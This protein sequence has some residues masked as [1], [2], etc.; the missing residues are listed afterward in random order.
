[1]KKKLIVVGIIVAIVAVIAIV[2]AAKCDH[3]WVDATCETPQT[4]SLCGE[5]NGEALG[6]KWVDAT[7]K[8]AKYC[9]VC[10]KIEGEALGHTTE[11]GACERCGEN[12]GVWRFTSY[13]DD[14]NNPTGEGVV[15][16]NL[17]FEGTFSNSAA[18]DKKLYAQL[19][20]DSNDV[21]IMLLEYGTYPV[22]GS[23]YKKYNVTIL[24]ENGKKYTTYAS[25][26]K[27]SDRLYIKDY[28]DII[29]YIQ[30]NEKI[31]FYIKEMP[32]YSSVPSE[33]LFTV[34]RDNFDLAY[35]KLAK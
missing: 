2:N 21:A 24:A 16:D 28:T 25:L 7:C 30:N 20:I 1:M 13:I 27:G 34:E 29:T 35:A 5:T 14:F 22:K 26:S 10:E 33:Y 4:C 19:L 17:Y 15:T 3:E 23:S 11:M 8:K 6:H 18:T 32:K 31:E 9:S 12:I